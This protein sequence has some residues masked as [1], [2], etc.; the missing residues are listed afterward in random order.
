VVRF[1]NLSAV[2]EGNRSE[3]VRALLGQG[4]LMQECGELDEAQRQGA[5]VGRVAEVEA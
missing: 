3:S 5:G 1:Y 4:A 2:S